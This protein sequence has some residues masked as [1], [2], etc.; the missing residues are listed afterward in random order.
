MS[1][2]TSH[3]ASEAG[4]QVLDE[5]RVSPHQDEVG[6]D[7]AADAT[8]TDDPDATSDDREHAA[9]VRTDAGAA[10]INPRSS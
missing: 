10:P 7:S 6:A 5:G 9:D 2:T 8:G 4:E 1:D 3:D